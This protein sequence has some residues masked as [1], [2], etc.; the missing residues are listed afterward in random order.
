M[1]LQNEFPRAEKIGFEFGSKLARR[2]STKPDDA[3][4]SASAIF[5]KLH[6]SQ[7][8]TLGTKLEAQRAFK[9]AAYRGYDEATK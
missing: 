6:N 3:I 1:P 4:H 2:F 5:I 8:S 7:Y 9:S